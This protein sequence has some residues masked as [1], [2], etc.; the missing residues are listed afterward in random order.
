MISWSLFILRPLVVNFLLLTE[1]FYGG[2]YGVREA[3][4]FLI[5]SIAGQTLLHGLLLR[6]AINN[7]L[8]IWKILKFELVFVGNIILWV[9]RLNFNLNQKVYVAVLVVDTKWKGKGA[10]EG[11]KSGEQ[12]LDL[13]CSQSL[14]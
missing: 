13:L 14:R 1:A 3:A 5:Q 11:P 2:F 8:I 9:Q 7:A 10:K 6:N 12:T 4:Q